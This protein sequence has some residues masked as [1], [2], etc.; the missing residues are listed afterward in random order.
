MTKER[1]KQSES[2]KKL[3]EADDYILTDEQRLRY[4]HNLL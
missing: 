4:L 3:L 1:L 2:S